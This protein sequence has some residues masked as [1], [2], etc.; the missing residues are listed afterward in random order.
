MLY[1]AFFITDDVGVVDRSQDS[2][3]IEG[4]LLLSLVKVVQFNFFYSVDL[5]VDEA[6]G[7][8]DA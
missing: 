8:V 1:E 7:L 4:V 5:V 2:H 3:F 6:L